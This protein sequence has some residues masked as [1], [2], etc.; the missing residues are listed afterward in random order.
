MQSFLIKIYIYR[1]LDA[2]KLIGVIFA[3]FFSQSGLNPFQISLLLS[4][5]SITTILTEVP[6]G[7]LADKYYRRNLLIIGLILL[8][9]GFCFWLK[10]GF[11]NFAIGFVFWGLKNTLTSGTLEAFVYD[12]LVAFGKEDQYER[13]SGKMGSAFSSGL[14][15]SAIFGGLM[16]EISFLWVLVASIATTLLAGVALLTIRQVKAIQSTG[17]TKYFQVVKEALSQIRGNATLPGNMYT[18]EV[19]RY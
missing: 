8:A 5:W 14:M 6:M 19:Y 10:G 9:I 12:E 15:L 1:F 11:I 17:E 4:I 13:V 7:V 2:F 16:A 18:S 3:L